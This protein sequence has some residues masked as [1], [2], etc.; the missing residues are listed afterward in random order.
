VGGEE[1]EKDGRK[2]TECMKKRKTK[3]WMR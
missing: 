1:K 3:K 2:D